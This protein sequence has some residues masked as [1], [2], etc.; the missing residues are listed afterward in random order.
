MATVRKNLEGAG[1]RVRFAR[2]ARS[3][4]LSGPRT[5]WSDRGEVAIKTDGMKTI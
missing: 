3:L 2:S 1:A 4:A 5:S